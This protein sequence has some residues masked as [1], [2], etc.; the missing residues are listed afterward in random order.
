MG[1]FSFIGDAWDDI[2]DFVSDTAGVVEDVGKVALP[3]L[4]ATGANMVVP[5]SGAIVGPL[6][7]GAQQVYYADKASDNAS[8]SVNQAMTQ[9]NT[10]QSQ[11]D[12]Y[13]QQVAGYGEEQLR[14]AIEQQTKWEEIFG[15][16]QEN[17]A[18]YYNSL[19]PDDILAP[20]VQAI[21][22][23]YQN[24]Q[25]NLD[26]VLSQRG[27]GTSGLSAQLTSQGMLTSEM[28]KAKAQS[29]APQ[30][31]AAQQVGFLNLGLSQSNA[32]RQNVS[33]AFRTS[34]LYG[35]EAINRA[36]GDVGS[37]SAVVD[38]TLANQGIATAN[39]QDTLV[40]IAKNIPWENVGAGLE[41]VSN[42]VSNWFDP[43]YGSVSQ[44]SNVSLP[45][46][47]YPGGSTW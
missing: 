8:A 27:I 39:T 30:V 7:G 21:Q 10:A 16:T 18:S 33:D 32:I 46:V 36:Y 31:A 20:K 1:L 2:E 9:A 45:E 4:A 25:T 28:E 22:Q 35:R 42:T 24:Y 37:A 41:S 26:K 29:E 12:M 34:A 47:M 15:S 38:N 17:L 23:G 14:W 40:N 11:Y 43:Q 13:A 19:S 5:G 44:T 3:A 6:V